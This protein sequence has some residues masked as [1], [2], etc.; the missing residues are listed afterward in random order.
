VFWFPGWQEVFL[1]YKA[2]T[3]CLAHHSSCC[4][5]YLCCTLLGG[6]TAVAWSWP[7]TSTWCQVEECVELYF[8]LPCLPAGCRQGQ[9]Y[10]Y[11]FMKWLSSV[12]W[13]ILI[14]RWGAAEGCTVPSV[15]PLSPSNKLGFKLSYELPTKCTMSV[16]D[17]LCWNTTNYLPINTVYH[18]RRAWISKVS[19]REAHDFTY[20][21]SNE[22]IHTVLFK[23]QK[24]NKNQLVHVSGH[25]GPSSGS[26]QLYKTV[27]SVSFLMMGCTGPKHVGFDFLILLYFL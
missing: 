5:G 7:V 27:V 21:N 3:G 13:W 8:C 6:E 25:I 14:C 24:Y 11:V 18:R 26:T 4:R 22:Q 20:C 10:L 12:Q 19:T 17:W 9:L 23:L 16:T 15:T 1:L 2:T